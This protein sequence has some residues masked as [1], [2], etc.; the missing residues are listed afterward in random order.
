MSLTA[1]EKRPTVLAVFLVIAGAIGFAAAFLLTLDK[2]T[3]LEHPKAQLSCNFSVL[4]GCS[5][6]LSS[7]QGAVLGFPN[8]LIGIACWPAV[9]AV[10]VSILAEAKFS[11]WFW[12]LFNLGVLGAI[13]L[14]GWLIW[15]SV[16]ALFVLCPWCMVTWSVTIPT[17]FAVTLYNLKM[18]NIPVP[19]GVR[20]ASAVLY[21]WV[22]LITIVC[23]AFV[24]IVAQVQLDWLHRI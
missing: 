9:I 2:F 20:R 22:P 7:P 19:A 17:F 15:Q 18:G 14:V 10:G 11:R 3:L 6:N 4:I 24:A 1:P 21:A 13:V 12:M 8:P 16:Y 5:T 23:Y